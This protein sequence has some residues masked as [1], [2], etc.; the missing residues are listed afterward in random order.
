M[1]NEQTIRD[2]VLLAYKAFDGTVKGKTMLQKRVYFLSVF[3]NAELGYEAHYYGP[4]SEAVATANLE[5]KSLGYLSESVAGW[6]V[7]QRGF[8]LARYD[9]K[10][11]EAGTRIADRKA[12]LHKELWSKIEAAARVVNDAGNLDYM[13]LSIAAK[14]YY[15]LTQMNHKATLEDIADMLPKF[16]WRVSKEELQK[17]TEFLQKANLVTKASAA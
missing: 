12:S 1:A 9:Y 7:D 10:L 14:A 16:G 13:E 17:A 3:L 6:G 11:T 8:E 15:I 2:V 5:M 4:Y